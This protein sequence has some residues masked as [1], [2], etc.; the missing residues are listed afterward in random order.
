MT[1]QKQKKWNT[2]YSKEMNIGDLEPGQNKVVS[3]DLVIN[4]ARKRYA[5]SILS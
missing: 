5:N 3:Y 4:K 1:Y 2:T